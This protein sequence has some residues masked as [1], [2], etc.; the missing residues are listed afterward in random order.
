[1]AGIV[2]AVQAGA[3]KLATLLGNVS[4]NQGGKVGALLA[5]AGQKLGAGV[6]AGVSQS[7]GIKTDNKVNVGKGSLVGLIVVAAVIVFIYKF[8]LKK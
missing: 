6:A 8:I 2:K 3:G 4:T 7:G 1:M 5:S